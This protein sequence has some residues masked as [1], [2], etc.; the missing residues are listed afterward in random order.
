V[1]EHLRGD[2]TRGDLQPPSRP[3]G[4]CRAAFPA[5]HHQRFEEITPQAGSV[6][7]ADPATAGAQLRQALALW[8]GEPLAEFT[9]E[10]FTQLEVPRLRERPL[11][12]VV[13]LMDTELTA[14]R[15]AEVIGELTEWA[16]RYQLNE[17]PPAQLMLRCTASNGPAVAGLVGPPRPRRR[18]RVDYLHPNSLH[19]F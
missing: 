2:A 18:D 6:A 16:A 1:F 15:H 14:G 3:S 7:A 5:D 9:T 11:D 12:A 13:A 4:S 10:S 17:R 8:R 19:V